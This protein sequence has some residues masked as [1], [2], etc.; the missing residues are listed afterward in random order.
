MNGEIYNVFAPCIAG[1]ERRKK[2]FSKDGLLGVEGI[3]ADVIR[4]ILIPFAGEDF[5][6]KSRVT[7]SRFFED[8]FSGGENS[9]ERRRKLAKL[10]ALPET[11]TA[12][13]LL[14]A[15]NLLITDEE[16]YEAVKRIDNE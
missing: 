7:K 11:L 3:E 14:E 12:K 8:G 4:K 2:S 5:K 13:A 6:K 16:Y 10:L 1:K 15:I 9:S